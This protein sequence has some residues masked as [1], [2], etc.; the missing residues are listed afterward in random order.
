MLDERD[1]TS[2]NFFSQAVPGSACEGRFKFE[3]ERIAE[4]LIRIRESP[5]HAFIRRRRA[6]E[7]AA[8][9]FPCR[10]LARNTDATSGMDE[11]RHRDDL[12]RVSRRRWTSL[13]TSMKNILRSGGMR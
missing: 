12:S 4:S 3:N 13:T 9:R 7:G 2:K 10:A 5:E 6:D 8:R 1:S 11:N